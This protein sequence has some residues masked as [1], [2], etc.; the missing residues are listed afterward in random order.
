MLIS[1]TA[2]CGISNIRA[3]ATL[4]AFLRLRLERLLWFSPEVTA[5]TEV[6][7]MNR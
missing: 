6:N 1:C 4:R 7:I 2:I 3:I 5:Q